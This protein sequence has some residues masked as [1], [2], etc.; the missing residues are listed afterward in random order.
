MNNIPQFEILITGIEPFLTHSLPLDTSWM[1]Y[2]VSIFS[3]REMCLIT[4]T[5]QQIHSERWFL[6]IL[7]H[8]AW[9]RP[10]DWQWNDLMA[11]NGMNMT[12]WLDMNGASLHNCLLDN[13]SW[14]IV[15][16][17]WQIEWTTLRDWT[18]EH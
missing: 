15:Q 8:C 2:N 9:M 1:L 6:H 10:E 11:R 17:R 18:R 14:D 3:E 13:R 7:R 4:M 16:I 12:V 5:P